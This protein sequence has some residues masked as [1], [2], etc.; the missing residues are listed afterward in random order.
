LRLVKAQEMA[1]VPAG[2]PVA[3][4]VADLRLHL[5]LPAGLA[6]RSA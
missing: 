3:Q 6:V 2:V 4:A 5:H 1:G